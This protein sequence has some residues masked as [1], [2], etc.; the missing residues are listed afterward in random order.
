MSPERST[1][2]ARPPGAGRDV[3]RLTLTIRDDAY[4]VRP[5]RPLPEGVWGAWRLGGPDGKAYLI[6]DGDAGAECDCPDFRF[7]HGGRDGGC[8]HVRAL[9]AVGL[10]E[11]PTP[12]ESW[13]GWTDGAR[14]AP[15]RPRGGPGG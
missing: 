1:T 7:R 10:L 5:A 11:R 3:C 6:T 4:S 2:P 15:G 9:R 12:A 8:K 14:Y 13:P